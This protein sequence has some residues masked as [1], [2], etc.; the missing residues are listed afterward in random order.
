MTNNNETN[1]IRKRPAY[2][3]FVKDVPEY[4][5]EV[6]RI[7]DLWEIPFEDAMSAAQ[8][9]LDEWHEGR[10]GDAT[11]DPHLVFIEHALSYLDPFNERK[12]MDDAR[13]LQYRVALKFWAR[14]GGYKVSEVWEWFD[15]VIAKYRDI[16]HIP[17]AD[18]VW[19]EFERRWP[20]TLPRDENGID[21][22]AL[23]QMT[24]L[25]RALITSQAAEVAHTCATGGGDDTWFDY[26][27]AGIETLA[28]L[29][30]EDW[31][32]VF[33]RY[34]NVMS[35]LS[36]EDM[37]R[38]SEDMDN[39]TTEEKLADELG[40]YIMDVTSHLVGIFLKGNMS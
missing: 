36:E 17:Y 35:A 3:R 20:I 6:K 23:D 12:I 34:I 10:F 13:T 8:K 18:D 38:E 21:A 4:V 25:Q 19:G 1:A 29:Q 37:D 33:A 2:N 39:E 31:A 30:A 32:D 11:R 7:S 14:Q 40:F 16:D 24:D 9:H 5:E 22:R 28:H 27:P 26:L 15:S